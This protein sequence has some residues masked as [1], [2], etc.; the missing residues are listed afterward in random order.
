MLK[1]ADVCNGSNIHVL[2]LKKSK[3]H[4]YCSNGVGTNL[5]RNE[6]PGRVHVHNLHVHG[7]VYLCN[8][9]FRI[10]VLLF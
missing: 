10:F 8:T 4:C 3:N 7:T 1:N 9:I 2:C 5:Y 6:K